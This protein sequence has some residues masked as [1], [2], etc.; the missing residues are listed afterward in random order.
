MARFCYLEYTQKV[1]FFQSTEQ[2]PSRGTH[3]H[4]RTA[5]QPDNHMLNCPPAT[6]LLASLVPHVSIS[7]RLRRLESSNMQNTDWPARGASIQVGVLD[8][9]AKVDSI[10]R[11]HALVHAH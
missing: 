5:N 11:T 6:F 8:G 3:I 4:S 1:S 9:D 2:K 7:F 10:N